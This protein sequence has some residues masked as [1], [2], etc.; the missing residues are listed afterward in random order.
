MHYRHGDAQTRIESSPWRIK[1]IQTKWEI[2]EAFYVIPP[3]THTSFHF[4]RR[5][6]DQ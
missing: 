5:G 1:K 6:I 3:A 4:L 2:K